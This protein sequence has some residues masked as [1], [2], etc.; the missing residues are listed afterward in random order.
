M[1][2]ERLA[3]GRG[4]EENDEHSGARSAGL[5]VPCKGKRIRGCKV[6]YEVTRQAG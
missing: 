5:H 1:T 6:D 4:S 2:T 3:S